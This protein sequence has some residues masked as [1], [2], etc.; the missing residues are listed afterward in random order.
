MGHR[1]ILHLVLVTLSLFTTVARVTLEMRS[2]TGMRHTAN[3]YTNL[4]SSLSS[5]R[6]KHV[7][8]PSGSLLVG[9]LQGNLW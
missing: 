5:A 4:Y 9:K 7:T 2:P 8:T 6:V 1:P 3:K